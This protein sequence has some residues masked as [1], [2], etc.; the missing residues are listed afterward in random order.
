M[1][2]RVAVFFD[3]VRDG[4]Q[5]EIEVS[6][7]VNGPEPDVGIF[8]PCCE[9][10]SAKGDITLTEKEEEAAAEKIAERYWHD[11]AEAWEDQP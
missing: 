5:L 6:G 11:A 4:Q 2:R 8:G 7:D 3:I 9:G 10:I 1:S